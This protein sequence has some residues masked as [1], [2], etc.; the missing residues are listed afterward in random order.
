MPFSDFALRNRLRAMGVNPLSGAQGPSTPGE[1]QQPG[2]L[3]SLFNTP[4]TNAAGG[5]FNSDQKRLLGLGGSLLSN[6]FGQSGGGIDGTL[7]SLL[8][9]RR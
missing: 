6:S 7:L 4:V 1:V 2:G 8:L 3:L 5:L 9:S